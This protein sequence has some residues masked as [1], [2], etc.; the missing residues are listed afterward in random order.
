V[1]VKKRPFLGNVEVSVVAE[2]ASEGECLNPDSANCSMVGR[3]RAG[4]PSVDGP[5]FLCS[6]QRVYTICDSM[7]GNGNVGTPKP[8]LFLVRKSLM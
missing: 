1:A 3:S 8:L 4:N 5:H 6:P 2:D 7:L